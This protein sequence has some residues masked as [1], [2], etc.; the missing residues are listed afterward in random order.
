[1][2]TESM[3]FY[4]HAPVVH[5]LLRYNRVE[6]CF[7]LWFRKITADPHT[8]AQVRQVRLR[9]NHASPQRGTG[10]GIALLFV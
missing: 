2:K 10:T 7:T 3:E 1:M 4:L 8:L 6:Q 9:I 5:H